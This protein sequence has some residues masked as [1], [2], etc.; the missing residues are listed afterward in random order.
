MSTTKETA[1]EADPGVPIIRTTRDF[2][3][4]PEQLFRA[5]TDPA[6]FVRWVG[7][8]DTATRIEH[9]DAHTGGSWRYV[10]E[11]NGTEYGFRGCFHEVRP[12]RIVQ[13]FTFEGDPDGVALETLRFE[14]LGDGRTRLRSQSLVD[15]FEG[16]DAWLRSGME[17]G[18]SEGYAKLER[19]IIDGSV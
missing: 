19:M 9:W 14:D 1:I 8:D 13:T 2:A 6:L 17:V 5:H 3:A 10:S 16:R 18:V 12:D 7:P 15:S 11:H 4:T